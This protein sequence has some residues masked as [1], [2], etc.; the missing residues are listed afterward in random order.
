[1]NQ[2]QDRDHVAKRLEELGRLAVR[3]DSVVE[4]LRDS[5]R[6]WRYQGRLVARQLDRIHVVI[7]ASFE[8]RNLS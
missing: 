2:G 4:R 1:M 8:F 7:R 3:C 6:E 5:L